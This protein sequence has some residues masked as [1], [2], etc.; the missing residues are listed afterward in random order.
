MKIVVSIEDNATLQFTSSYRS[1]SLT[2]Q[3][4]LGCS[5]IVISTDYIYLNFP[6]MMCTCHHI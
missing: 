5:R 6:K 1:Y 2:K 4:A 3:V